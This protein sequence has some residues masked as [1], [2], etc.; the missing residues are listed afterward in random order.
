[1]RPI[2]PIIAAMCTCA[3]MVSSGVPVHATTAPTATISVII[4]APPSVE[5]TLTT[6]LLSGGIDVTADFCTTGFTDDPSLRPTLGCTA[7]PD[8]TYEVQIVSSNPD[9]Q[10]SKRCND[11]A[12]PVD[13]I[14]IGNGFA[15][16]GCE[17]IASTPGIILGPDS[18]T[19][20]EPVP[21][22]PT[23]ALLDSNG[24][25][26][27]AACEP[28]IV[29][30]V[31]RLWCAGLPDG[32]YTAAIDVPA[33]Y[34]SQVNCYTPADLTT[35]TGPAEATVSTDDW[36]W[37]CVPRAPQPPLAIYV[38][39]N[40][41]E[42]TPAWFADAG[43]SVVGPDGDVSSSCLKVQTVDGPVPPP[44]FVIHCPGIPDGSYAVTVSGIPQGLDVASD[45]AAIMVNGS[46]LA[47]CNVVFSQPFVPPASTEPPGS[48]SPF[49]EPTGTDGTL[50]V[51]GQ[52]TARTAAWLG[53]AAFGVGAALVAGTRRRSVMR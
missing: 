39:S 16:V 52:R 25:D 31:E 12:T 1:M 46:E 44:Y 35:D 38:G 2:S 45:C 21:A 27:T 20:P 5:S 40:V 47:Q 37:F 51:T 19:S 23:I 6:T 50:P 43:Y 34:R 13:P 10:I 53:L 8:G 24:N 18:Q 26:I 33:G 42:P 32:I 17:V 7:V 41:N 29:N 30:G 49:P 4:T 14:V 48:V 15:Q 28:D 3:G 22:P 11:L 9:V 36:L